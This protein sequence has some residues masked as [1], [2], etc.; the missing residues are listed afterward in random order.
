[1][2]ELEMFHVGVNEKGEEL[3]NVRYK[4]GGMTLPTPSMTKA[5]AQAMIGGEEISDTENYH[6]MNKKDLE[7][8][9]RGHGI[10]LDRR[11]TKSDLLKQ[12]DDFFKD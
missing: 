1:M 5:E 2:S 3:Y 9:M 12:V 11:K 7:T 8:F 6:G 10:E 4:K